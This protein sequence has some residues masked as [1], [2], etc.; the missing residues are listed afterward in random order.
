MPELTVIDSPPAPKNG[1]SVAK[2][3]T[4][5]MK[6]YD[7]IM[8]HSIPELCKF[9]EN[10]ANTDMIPVGMKNKPGNILGAVLYGMEIGLGIMQSI[11]KVT[12]IN[13]KPC[14]EAATIKALAMASPVFKDIQEGYLTDDAGAVFGAWCRAFRK[15]GS[16]PHYVE[17]TLDDA[18][19]AGLLAKG[20]VWATYPKRMLLARARAFCMKDFFG[21]VLGGIVAREE[22]EDYAE[23]VEHREVA[24]QP[25]PNDV[26]SRMLARMGIKEIEA[27]AAKP[28]S[29]AA[30]KREQIALL[31]ATPGWFPAEDDRPAFAKQLSELTGKDIKTAD[32]KAV[33]GDDIKRARETLEKANSARAEE[34]ENT[35]E[36]PELELVP[37]E[38]DLGDPFAD[39]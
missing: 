37:D 31:V 8:P 35:P 3:S 34:A 38:E 4:P 30:Y 9:I 33:T 23:D 28:L 1:T 26:Q 29:P 25:A 10:I 2:R 5:A 13:G 7:E 39:E 15:D 20:G 32:L 22:V 12:L 16:T 6:M 27:P 36:A 21:D 19:K 14:V 11:Q 18:K 17:F 24:P